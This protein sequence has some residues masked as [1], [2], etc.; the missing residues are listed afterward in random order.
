MKTTTV[1]NRF[2]SPGGDKGAGDTGKKGDQGTRGDQSTRREEELEEGGSQRTGNK[3]TI[4]GDEGKS[5]GGQRSGQDTGTRS[6]QSG[7]QGQKG[8]GYQ[9]GE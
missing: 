2:F 6:G 8:Q 9:G 7:Q 3:G 1:F 5:Q 4:E